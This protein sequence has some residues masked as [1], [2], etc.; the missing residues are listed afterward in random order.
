M[1]D[2]IPQTVYLHGIYELLLKLLNIISL[3]LQKN[4]GYQYV[5]DADLK[6]T[7]SLY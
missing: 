2:I 4:G 7:I 1:H 3:I 6:F 5:W